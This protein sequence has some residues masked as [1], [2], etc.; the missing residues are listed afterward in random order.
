MYVDSFGFNALTLSHPFPLD[1]RRWNK[2][3]RR[4]SNLAVNSRESPT[5]HQLF[6]RISGRMMLLRHIRAH[7]RDSGDPQ[8][9]RSQ[10]CKSLQIEMMS[11][12]PPDFLDHYTTSNA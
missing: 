10:E 11:S 7:G 3:D 4:E 8:G 9:K 1:L 2:R 6:C 5:A 12:T